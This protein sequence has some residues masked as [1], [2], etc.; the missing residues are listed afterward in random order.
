MSKVKIML[1]R[2]MKGK[3]REQI[4]KEE[5]EMVDVIFGMYDHMTCEIISSIVENPEKKS[6][7]ECFSE[8]IFFMS[9]A[10]VL[11]MGFGWEN[12]RG[13]R[14]EH[15]IAKA[16]G[17]PVIYLDG[18]EKKAKRDFTSRELHDDNSE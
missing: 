5:K 12:S 1:S 13:C 14:L 2:P 15:D 16:Y 11:A 17:V 4:E 8:S 18:N 7:L 10:D 6:E 3:T 9:K